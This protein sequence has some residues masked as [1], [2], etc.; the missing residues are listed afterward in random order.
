MK[1]VTVIELKGIQDTPANIATLMESDA[2]LD[3][4]VTKAKATRLNYLNDAFT[5]WYSR[6]LGS[7]PMCLT[8]GD[9]HLLFSLNPLKVVKL[10]A[11]GPAASYRASV[12]AH[13]YAIDNG[14][15]G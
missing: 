12:A 2:L 1:N 15:Q 13:A 10:T 6:P 7:T 4:G 11:V 9:G 14:T 5:G 8:E 3:V